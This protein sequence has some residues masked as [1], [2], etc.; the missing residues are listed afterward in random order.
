MFSKSTDSQD[1]AL[2]YA[3][4]IINTVRDPLIALDQDLR[5]VTASRAF[6]D[7][8]KVNP[9]ETIGQFIYDLGNKQ[10][11]IPKLR[12]LL[13]NILPQKT[14]FDNYELEHVFSTIGKR[15][16][17]LN[18]RQID[19]V[20]GKKRI[21][22]LA[23]EDIT[24][25]KEAEALKEQALAYAE[26]II[27]TVRDPL[28]ALDQ[29]LRVVTASRAFYDVFKVNPQET[30]GQFIYDLGNKQWDIPKLRDLLEH[31]LPQKTVFDNYELEHVFSTIGKRTMLL[32]AR[33]I[34]EVLGKKRIILLSIEDIT[35][36]WEKGEKLKIMAQD[37]TKSNKELEK[38]NE[39]LKELDSL[40][41][42]FVNSVSHELR[43]P[44][45]IIKESIALVYDQ[46]IG[47][48]SLKQKDFL[49]TARSNV[50]RLARMIHNVLDYQKLDAQK[51]EFDMV[52]GN[53]ND[54]VK[55]VGEGFKISLNNKGL[56]LE[57]QLQEDLP[58]VKFD[59][60]K[61]IQVLT[62]YIN[63]ALK[64]T[65]KGKIYL[66]TEKEGENAVRVSV[67]DEGIGIKEEDLDKL[68]QAFSQ[69]SSE[70]EIQVGGTGLGLALCKKII[71]SLKGRVGIASE[72]GR[73]STFYFILPIQVRRPNDKKFLSF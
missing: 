70:V 35:E 58:F 40:K 63:N 11:D 10:W 52:E 44:L 47:P 24:E 23:I 45:T 73:G 33:Q 43:T 72:F 30:I 68:F 4:S 59:K 2:A 12:D 18:A 39:E 26:S 3:E 25:R 46:T 31:I 61:I 15:T 54:V 48:I 34:D 21:I 66:V 53:I 27:N 36:S 65:E 62:N 55:E 38:K 29:D 14:T 8:F 20:L 13:E 51:T 64:F 6:Y 42:D 56:D 49:E 1:Q 22:L 60:D 9:Q 17:L 50:D 71:E 57:F 67:K 41:N 7:V 69:I 37:L 28:I 16:M 32:N 19:E 5:V